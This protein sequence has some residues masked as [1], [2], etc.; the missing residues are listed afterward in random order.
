MKMRL[1]IL[2]L[3]LLMASCASDRV[4][5]L[6]E[7]AS[8]RSPPD[9]GLSWLVQQQRAD[10]SWGTSENRVALTSL[11]TLAFL[12]RCETPSSPAYGEAVE[13]A[14]RALIRLSADGE[15]P[16]S[17]D[18]ALLTWCLAEAY[19]LTQVPMLLGP[20]QK[21]AAA[22]DAL[23]P[24]PWHAFAARALQL[25]GAVPDIGPELLSR[26]KPAYA[27]S[28]DSRLGKASHLL[29]MMWTGD[30]EKSAA[31]LERLRR[32]D[33]GEWRTGNRPIETAAVLSLVL[34]Y[35]GGEACQEWQQMFYPDLVR[36]QRVKDDLG[37]W[38][39]EGLGIDDASEIDG[40]TLEEG[41]IYTTSLMLLTLHQRRT[42]PVFRPPAEDYDQL[43]EDDDD[44]D[45][46]IF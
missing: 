3:A 17:N 34:F 33:I 22:L 44:L 43:F 41:A 42:L 28:T 23:A 46:E 27:A 8:T 5:E 36:N 40:M 26:L 25:S 18:R 45:I 32:Q 7:S 6:D 35:V 30:W 29:V 19:A 37:W 15:S 31:C 1:P 4:P 13:K 20:L 39:A 16:D 10:G 21:H 14:L 38:T 11:A 12:Y 2:M 9:R 24:S